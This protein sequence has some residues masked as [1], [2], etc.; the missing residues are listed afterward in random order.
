M[1]QGFL[2]L[3]N[4][5]LSPYVY[6]YLFVYMYMCGGIHVHD[7]HFKIIRQFLN[8]SSL[9][10]NCDIQVGTQITRFGLGFELSQWVITLPL[11]SK[12][13][14]MVRCRDKFFILYDFNYYEITFCYQ[15][16][17]TWGSRVH[18]IPSDVVSSIYHCIKD[19]DFIFKEMMTKIINYFL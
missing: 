13:F 8:I 18:K 11:L 4:F 14:L 7:V 19:I 10:Q 9:F 15:Y 2:F 12:L 1:L 5:L 16:A 3:L 17:M 6:L